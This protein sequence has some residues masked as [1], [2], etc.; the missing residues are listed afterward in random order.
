MPD[1]NPDQG[2][3]ITNKYIYLKAN[4]SNCVRAVD[5]K[6]IHC[7]S[8]NNSGSMFYNYIKYFSIVLMTIMDANMVLFQSMSVHMVRAILQFSKNAHLGKNYTLNY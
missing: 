4:F 6:H 1:L 5:G 2:L 8:P 7:V 3:E